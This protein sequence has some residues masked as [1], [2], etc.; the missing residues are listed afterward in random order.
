MAHVFVTGGTGYVGS[1]LIPRLSERGHT[2]RALARK[3]SVHKLPQGCIPVIGN[4]LVTISQM[5]AAL[6]DAVEAPPQGVTIVEVNQIR[7]TGLAHHLTAA[8]ARA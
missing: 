4:A 5:L 1:R 6:V 3:G 2:V 8:A 7:T